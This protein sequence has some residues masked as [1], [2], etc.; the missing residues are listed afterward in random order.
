MRLR[1]NSVAAFVST[2]ML[3]PAALAEPLPPTEPGLV[4][5]TRSVELTI[6]RGHARM[7]VV[8]EVRRGGGPPQTMLHLPVPWGAVATGL[9]TRATLGGRTVWHEGELIAAGLAAQRYEEPTSSGGAPNRALLS[10]HPQR[11]LALHVTPRPKESVGVG[12][13][14]ELATTW[15]DGRE[16]LGLHPTEPD[17]GTWA[18]VRTDVPGGRLFVDGKPVPSGYRLRI[19]AVHVV[20]VEPPRGRD[21]VEGRLAAVSLGPDRSLVALRFDAPKQISE[22]PRGARIVIALDTSR[23]LSADDVGAEMG[24]AHAYL[25]HFE[26]KDARVALVAFDRHARD[27]TRG[28]VTVPVARGLLAGPALP[29]ANGSAI[30]EAFARAVSLLA[31]VP[32]SAPK[33][34]VVLGDLLTRRGVEP[35]GIA[36]PPGAIV[37]LASVSD[38]GPSVQRVDDHPWAAL[39]RSTGGLLFGRSTWQRPAAAAI[40]QARFVGDFLEW[41]RPVQLDHMVWR[42]PGS[43]GWGDAPGVLPEGGSVSY[44]ELQAELPSEA[45]IEGELWSTRIAKTISPSESEGKLWSALVFGTDMERALSEEEMGALAHAGGAVS[46]VTSY[47]VKGPGTRRS[48]E[49]RQRREGICGCR[50]PEPIGMGTGPSTEHRFLAPDYHRVFASW[51]KRSV[52]E[53]GG[54][55][56]TRISA[57]TTAGE[58]VVVHVEVE[59][60][61]PDGSQAG[62]VREATWALELP[63]ELGHPHLDLKASL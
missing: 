12:Y 39:P 45:T 36:T 63:D 15:K 55:G 46:P 59:G 17:P 48:V 42:V 54:E 33:R 50:F 53:C 13:D 51:M 49:V 7:R 43:L 9:R 18:T 21:V 34:V 62:C 14:L 28:F 27:L 60:D 40:A 22:V 10:W 32:A 30:E 38:G 52:R 58:I 47:A 3:A 31:S 1:P 29:R 25:A 26:G 24:A 37:H 57:E 20:E 19:D 41:A 2:L 6:S 44:S 8:T 4:E 5:R 23:S 61:A 11:W 35:T 16:G 56:R